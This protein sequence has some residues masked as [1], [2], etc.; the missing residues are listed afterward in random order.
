MRLDYA[1]DRGASMRA[2]ALTAGAVAVITAGELALRAAL[3]AGAT[4]P[5]GAVALG[6]PPAIAT[7]AWGSL[8][9][10]RPARFVGAWLT[11][12]AAVYLFPSAPVAATWTEVG[13]LFAAG[14]AS[15]LT[16]N[17]AFE[18][19]LSA[20]ARGRQ[21]TATTPLT[22]RATARLPGVAG[23]PVRT[24]PGEEPQGRW[25][26]ARADLARLPAPWGSGTPGL[27]GT[28]RWAWTVARRPGYWGLVS[29]TGVFALITA[30]PPLGPVPGLVAPGALLSPRCS[31]PRSSA[32]E[33]GRPRP[34]CS[35]GSPTS[36][37]Q[38]P[39][40][41][42]PCSRPRPATRRG[43]CARAC[44]ADA[45]A[46]SSSRATRCGARRRVWSTSGPRTPT[47][48]ASRGCAPSSRTD[49]TCG[50]GT[51]RCTARWTSG[52]RAWSRTPTAP[53][54]VRC[55]CG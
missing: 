30:F 45:T 47:G 37:R 7:L 41:P 36:C 52:G 21:R 34:R 31:P 23:A 24:Y 1:R 3:G 13:V 32:G 19:V 46:G 6:L 42:C 12:S 50:P 4:T 40:V 17:V 8:V 49:A 25:S 54:A 48:R 11:G 44:G 43:G 55:P 33:S 35:P 38:A 29:W 39:G 10:A 22:G 28:L 14:L 9:A 20:I 18:F 53:A 2:A 15:V 5:W 27:H 51:T 16:A 26:Q